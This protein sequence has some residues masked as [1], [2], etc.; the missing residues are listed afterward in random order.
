MTAPNLFKREEFPYEHFQTQMD[1][2]GDALYD[3]MIILCK[4][5]GGGYRDTLSSFAKR[6][7]KL[8]QYKDFNKQPYFREGL[9]NSRGVKFIKNCL[10]NVRFGEKI[11]YFEDQRKNNHR[12]K[13]FSDEHI[14]KLATEQLNDQQT[15]GHSQFKFWKQRTS[16]KQ[17]AWST[18]SDRVSEYVG[19]GTWSKNKAITLKDKHKEHREKFGKFIL[20]SKT[21]NL[22]SHRFKEYRPVVFQ[23][24]S[25]WPSN[26]PL[27][28]P[29]V[30]HRYDKFEPEPDKKIGNRR[31]IP[32]NTERF[33]FSIAF[34]R[35]KKFGIKFF[36][37]KYYY[38]NRPKN[39]KEYKYK[40][41]EVNDETI[42]EK[43]IKE[44]LKNFP[45]GHVLLWDGASTHSQECVD[46]IREETEDMDVIDTIAVNEKW[47][48]KHFKYPSLSPDCNPCEN[49]LAILKQRALELLSK[50]APDEKW[51]ISKGRQALRVEWRNIT[52]EE[53]GNCIDAAE[54]SWETTAK[55]GGEW[56]RD[57]RYYKKKHKGHIALGTNVIEFSEEDDSE[58]MSEYNDNNNRYYY[59]YRPKRR[60]L[61]NRHQEEDEDTFSV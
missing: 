32:K 1:Q 7:R 54:R 12:P 31:K 3:K 43:V 13:K 33:M 29:V 55:I 15:L 23:D 37:E 38:K 44:Q 51:T 53:I 10:L 21:K 39:R 5:F 18:Y 27:V 6:F 19:T 47:N 2:G 41:I 59:E 20:K 56:T 57:S 17:I 8:N 40:R 24:E 34:S 22:W 42:L 11:I 16:P 14:Q 60:D 25:W 58:N 35:E 52:F 28:N 30:K 4:Y 50:E 26:T 46:Y 61:I 45:P 9:R 49:V 36:T 48:K